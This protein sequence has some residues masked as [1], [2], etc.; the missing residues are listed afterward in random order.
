MHDTPAW[1]KWT[2]GIVGTIVLGAIGSGLWERVGDP[3]FNL[4]RD[5]ALNLATFG[6]RQLKDALY[7][8][9]GK[10]LYERPSTQLLALFVMTVTYLSFVFSLLMHRALTRLTDEVDNPTPPS[11]KAGYLRKLRVSV[12]SFG[13]QFLSRFHRSCLLSSGSITPAGQ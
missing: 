1:Q 10:G 3:L 9:I 8:D 11:D 2:G 6:V 4:L 5:G 12:F 13:L 7:A